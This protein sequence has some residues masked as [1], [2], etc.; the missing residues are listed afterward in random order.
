[1]RIE[2][3]AVQYR[4]YFLTK[5]GEIA[6][7]EVLDCVTDVQAIARAEA[8]M[9]EREA[10]AIELWLLARRVHAAKRAMT[11]SADED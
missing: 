10:A 9:R 5:A 6:G 2:G 1:L 8:L 11:P 7:L 4:C 3:W